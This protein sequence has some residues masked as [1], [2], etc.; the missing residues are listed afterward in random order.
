MSTMDIWADKNTFA[1]SAAAEARYKDTIS[2]EAI[3]DE[4]ARILESSMFVQSDRLGRFLSFTVET[5]LAGEAETL[6]EYLIGTE[7]YS[8]NSSYNTSED[9]IVRSEA[10]R[11]RRKLK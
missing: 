9:S 4:L 2:E 3:R 7:V 11:L 8:R 10:R 5:T 6:K 1:A